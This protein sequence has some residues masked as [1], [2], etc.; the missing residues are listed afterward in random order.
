MAGRISANYDLIKAN[1]LIESYI[2]KDDSYAEAELRSMVLEGDEIIDALDNIRFEF[3][4]EKEELKEKILKYANR[5]K[6]YHKIIR[7]LRQP[8]KELI[9][10]LESLIK[11]KEG[12]FI[13][14]IKEILK[15]AK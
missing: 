1:N 11:G 12:L 15:N 10:N 4:E 9:K 8:Q 7:E 14:K 5:I 3:D 6:D 13:N 2:N